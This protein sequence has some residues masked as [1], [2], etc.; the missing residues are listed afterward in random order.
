M[1]MNDVFSNMA[2]NNPVSIMGTV[3]MVVGI[4]MLIAGIILAVILKK[5]SK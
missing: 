5:R 2:A 1:Q 4:I 3:I